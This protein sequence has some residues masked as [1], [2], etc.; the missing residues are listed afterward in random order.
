MP[1]LLAR[2]EA[3][4][5]RYFKTATENPVVIAGPLFVNLVTREVLLNQKPIQLTRKE[6]RLLYILAMHVG[7][8]V[9]HDH[10]SMKSRLGT[11]AKTFSICAAS[12]AN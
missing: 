2:S 9:T 8:V 11:S 4:L 12:C 1:E 5:R 6:Y 3:A 7:L 10:F